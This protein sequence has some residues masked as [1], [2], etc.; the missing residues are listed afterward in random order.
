MNVRDRNLLNKWFSDQ[1]DQDEDIMILN[2][3]MMQS[4]EALT[5]SILELIRSG[6][7]LTGIYKKDNDLL[8]RLRLLE[9][10]IASLNP[11]V[12]DYFRG[13]KQ[14]NLYYKKFSVMYEADP[15]GGLVTAL[16]SLPFTLN[17]GSFRLIRNKEIP[18]HHI[19]YKGGDIIVNDPYV[20]GFTDFFICGSSDHK[21][22]MKVN[23]TNKELVS[24]LECLNVVFTPPRIRSRV[25]LVSMDI[26]IAS[27]KDLFMTPNNL[28][29]STTTIPEIIYNQGVLI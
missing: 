24:S 15:L 3:I 7:G 27:A 6:Y 8:H 12:Q 23:L 11:V 14:E 10:Q 13:F 29:D 17:Q 5:N 20:S 1:K 2:A 21:L 9:N 22:Q 4:K 18:I 25:D 16:K 19:I 26:S 28:Q